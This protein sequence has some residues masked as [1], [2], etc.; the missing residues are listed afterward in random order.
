MLD[1]AKP[2]CERWGVAKVTVD[3]IAA[4]S[5]RVAGHAVP[6][7][8]RRQGRAVRG[9]A[10]ARARRVLH[11]LTRRGRRTRRPRGTARAHR[12]RTPPAS[13]AADDHLA[14]MLAS[15]PGET[16]S[17]LTVD[18]LP[19]IIRMAT[20]YLTPLVAP[21]LDRANAARLDRPARPPHDL[22]LPRAERPRRP[23]RSEHPPARSSP[24]ASCPPF[25]PPAVQPT[26]TP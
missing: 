3:D 23:R 9:A 7:V 11:P 2:C 26:S 8:P 15:E 5:R 14:L 1:A 21:Y 25:V 18:G 10:R 12:R 24:P 6:A 4:A 17:Q 13:C 22:V 20:E 16:L 19:R